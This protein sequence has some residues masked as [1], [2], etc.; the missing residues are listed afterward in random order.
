V[1]CA[2]QTGTD[3]DVVIAVGGAITR[4]V[5]DQYQLGMRG[6]A[7]HVADLGAAVQVLAARCALR[8]GE[9][10]PP[11]DGGEAVSGR[12]RSRRQRGYHPC[13]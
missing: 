8:P 2:A 6:L 4:A 13:R 9:L 7:A 10:A 11:D 12:G 3:R 1:A 5:E